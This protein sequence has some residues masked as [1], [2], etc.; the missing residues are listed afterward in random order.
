[1]AAAW[2]RVSRLLDRL[3]GR[4]IYPWLDSCILL[5]FSLFWKLTRRMDDL[6]MERATQ[7]HS[8]YLTSIGAFFQRTRAVA[9]F[10]IEAGWCNVSFPF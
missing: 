9:A 3:D 10:F 4:M 6:I 5:S 7:R 1:M 2:P 8:T